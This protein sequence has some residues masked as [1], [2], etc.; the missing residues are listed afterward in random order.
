MPTLTGQERNLMFTLTP[1]L[2]GKVYF[3]SLAY[4]PDRKTNPSANECN[5]VV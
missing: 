4:K 1:I 5:A 3:S 2:N